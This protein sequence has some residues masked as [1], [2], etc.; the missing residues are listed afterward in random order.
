MRPTIALVLSVLCATAGLVGCGRFAPG[1]IVT[2]NGD[3]IANTDENQRAQAVK[4]IRTQLDA[5]LGG[6]WRTEAA[7]AELPLYDPD[8][9]H[10]DSGWQWPTATV[11][12]TLVGDGSAPLPFK[13]EHLREV[14]YDYLSPR[15]D[16]P[17]HHLTVTVTDVTDAARFAALGS[18]SA[19]PA[20]S[21][22]ARPASPAAPAGER[23]YTVQEG[24]TFADLSLAFYGTPEHWRR[25][26]KANPALGDGPLKP[27]TVIVI[28][29]K[30]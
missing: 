16:H 15:V 12:V 20:A 23:R 17:K 10:S 11:T 9:R 29:A 25:I 21:Q 5:Q 1:F 14:V 22:T 2:D 27:G 3:M 13:L 18:A 6:H 30:P 28:P 4:T 26:A 7:I 8:D 19:D 24:D